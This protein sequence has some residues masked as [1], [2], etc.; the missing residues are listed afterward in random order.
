MNEEI[1]YIGIVDEEEINK[2]PNRKSS[3][4]N[5]KDEKIKINKYNRKV[6]KFI[7]NTK[8][9]I[10]NKK[11][12]IFM[13][14]IALIYFLKPITYLRA[15][16]DE[17]R[18]YYTQFTSNSF[19]GNGIIEYIVYMSGF[20][21]Y[22]NLKNTMVYPA[23]G[24]LTY[25]YDLVHKGIDITC[26]EY[27]GN[28]YAVTNGYVVSVGYSE[29]Y[30]NDI[31]IQHNIN[32]MEVYT[33][34]ANLST[35]NVEQ[36]QHVYQNEVIGLEGGNPNKKAQVMDSEGHHIHFEVRKSKDSN[37]GLNPLIFLVE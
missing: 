23:D 14:C 7:A 18:E 26:D 12:I 24:S 28:V 16:L 37:S 36:G 13:L 31:L 15:K 9:R 19:S 34:Y 20:E 6:E 21:Y 30:G 8:S 33:Y 35:I 10:L 29:Q 2:K 1:K 3:S 5:N 32:G 22:K 11:V 27:P 17:K 4:K 25:T